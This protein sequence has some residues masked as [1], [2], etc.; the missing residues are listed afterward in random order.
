[1]CCLLATGKKRLTDFV[2]FPVLKNGV[3][4]AY[5]IVLD[6]CF[7]CPLWSKQKIQGTYFPASENSFENRGKNADKCGYSNF[8]PPGASVFCIE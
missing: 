3:R 6:I 5:C 8:V 4:R 2:S 1:M 7:I